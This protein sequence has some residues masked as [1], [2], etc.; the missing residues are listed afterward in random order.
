MPFDQEANLINYPLCLSFSEKVMPLHVHFRI[1]L[2]YGKNVLEVGIT[3][4]GSLIRPKQTR[5]RKTLKRTLHGIA[6]PKLI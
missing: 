4:R 3:A 5:A 2:F 6:L 1:A